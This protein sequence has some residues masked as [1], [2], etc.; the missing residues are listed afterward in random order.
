[1]SLLPSFHSHQLP[2]SKLSASETTRTESRGDELVVFADRVLG[3]EYS[4]TPYRRGAAA[5]ERGVLFF[6]EHDTDHSN[7][8]LIASDGG[9]SNID[10]A[11]VNRTAT[12]ATAG[13][14]ALSLEEYIE[15]WDW[16][17]QL[18]AMSQSATYDTCMDLGI[19]AEE[20]FPCQA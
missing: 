4:M 3:E 2:T 6:S 5:Q 19:V 1:M 14:N 11:L 18:Q 20:S 9:H 16:D 13:I 12:S 10:E 8:W 17:T 7:G 15:S